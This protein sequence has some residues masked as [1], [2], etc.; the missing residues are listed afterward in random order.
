MSTWTQKVTT[1]D[2]V[3]Y[4]LQEECFLCVLYVFLQVPEE[5]QR[6]SCFSKI[7]PMENHVCIYET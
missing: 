3:T 1:G 4:L 5:M 7:H 2:Q 6:R